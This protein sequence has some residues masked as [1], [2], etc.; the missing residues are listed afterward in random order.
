M[1][2]QALTR[3]LMRHFLLPDL[4]PR[5]HECG[6]GRRFYSL[7]QWAEHVTDAIYPRS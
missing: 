5:P 7:Q 1:N 2:R 4:Y 3:L 6:C